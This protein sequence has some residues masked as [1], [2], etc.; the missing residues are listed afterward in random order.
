MVCWIVIPFTLSAISLIGSWTVYG[1]AVSYKHVCPLSNWKYTDVCHPNASEQ[2]CTDGNMPM[3]SSCGKN[4]PE[5]SLFTATFNA[6]AVL[7]LI[8]CICQ[9]AHI[10]DKN[11]NYALLSK[12]N[13]AI[14]CLAAFGAFVTGNCNPVHVRWLHYLGAALGFVC[15]C[16]Y[17]LI[18][19]ILT[20]K[21]FITGL[22]RF[23][24]P[25]RII[26]TVVQAL[27]T[28]FYVVFFVQPEYNYKH[29]SAICE[30]T[31]STN[32]QLF[33]LTY[34]AEFYYFSSSMLSVLIHKRD[35]E[36]SLILS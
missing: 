32:I 27:S 13:L 9:H 2:C 15:L 5:N 8:F 14:G 17:T 18:L 23:L 31:L 11:S 22:E 21:C 20:S 33:E 26:L 35:E 28:I 7:F 12:A 4:P 30:W 36:K 19:T 1:L 34:V 6:A 10:L 24:A 25:L 29:M 16:F 3:I